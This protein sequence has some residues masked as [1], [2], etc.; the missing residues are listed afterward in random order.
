MWGFKKVLKNTYLGAKKFLH[1]ATRIVSKVLPVVK[2]ALPFVPYGNYIKTGIDFV[3]SAMGAAESLKA[4]LPTIEAG[5]RAVRDVYR[6][7]RD[8]RERGLESVI[9]DQPRGQRERLGMRPNPRQGVATTQQSVR[10]WGGQYNGGN[11]NLGRGNFK[12][13]IPQMRPNGLR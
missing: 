10:N 2:M 5:A 12:S 11:R 9:Q 3:E 1:G 6:T 7:G 13:N 8:I 4:K